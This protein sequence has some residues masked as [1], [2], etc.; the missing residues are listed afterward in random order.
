MTDNA[1]GRWWDVTWNPATGCSPISLGC[2]N[3]WA[4]RMAKR[5][6]G[7]CGYPDDEPFRVTLHPD[8]L[9]QPLHW[10]KPRRIFVA[11]MGDL[12]HNE[13]PIRFI[14]AVFGVMARARQHTFLVLTKR[15]KRMCNYLT[16]TSASCRAGSMAAAARSI[17][18]QPRLGDHDYCELAGYIEEQPYLP[19]VSLGVTAE[20]QQTVDE[21]IPILLSCPAAVRFVSC[22]PLLGPI[23]LSPYLRERGGG[24]FPIGLPRQQPKLR[25]S[26]HQP[27]L[28]WTIV[29]G[30][31]GPGARPMHPQWARSIRDQCAAARAPLFFKG[32]GEYLPLAACDDGTIMRFRDRYGYGRC[33]PELIRYGYADGRGFSP[34]GDGR[35]HDDGSRDGPIMLRVGR[36]KAGRLLDGREHNEIPE[37]R[38]G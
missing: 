29:G 10:R 1:Q 18:G 14:D 13:V 31:T 35:P 4:R 38:H 22:E 9:E 6:R 3:C 25:E 24:N 5:L 27:A 26:C 37:V 2:Q 19:N 20:N 17:P 21:R 16:G 34:A 23:D 15:P 8:R 11:D 28:S 12:F 30:E 7:R 33:S 32:W 36:K